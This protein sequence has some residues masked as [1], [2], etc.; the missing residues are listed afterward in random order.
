MGGEGRGA[1]GL[2]KQGVVSLYLVS[3][4]TEDL[5]TPEPMVHELIGMFN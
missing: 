4:E 2:Q 1:T 5:L 3:V